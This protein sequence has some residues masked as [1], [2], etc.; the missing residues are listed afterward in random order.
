MTTVYTL[1]T[2][3]TGLIQLKSHFWLFFNQLCIFQISRY[4]NPPQSRVFETELPWILK[5][6]TIQDSDSRPS[7]KLRN[8]P[9]KIP[10]IPLHNESDGG[11][12]NRGR[13]HRLHYTARTLNTT[14]T[15]FN[16]ITG[17]AR[18]RSKPLNVRGHFHNLPS[19]I[20]PAPGIPQIHQWNEVLPQ[21]LI[22]RPTAPLPFSFRG[23]SPIV[24]PPLSCWPHI[25]PPLV[26]R[27]LAHSSRR[28]RHFSHD[29]IVPRSQHFVRKS[30]TRLSTVD[31][32][33]CFVCFFL[34]FSSKII[35]L[36]I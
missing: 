21:Q 35:I 3:I 32:V 36:S 4:N 25:P 24:P 22:T 29:P 13:D 15:S 31:G 2:K 14:G 28:M 8:K 7:S 19:A 5:P 10:T 11:L 6:I 27:P 33:C 34:F 26:S 17:Q 16:G 1:A 18:L 12:S 9:V 23:D 20:Q 30:G